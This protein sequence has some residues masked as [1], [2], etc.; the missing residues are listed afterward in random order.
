MIGPRYRDAKTKQ[1]KRRFQLEVLEGRQMLSGATAAHELLQ[2]MT[3]HGVA[4][5]A[6][7]STQ[8]SVA[9]PTLAV[10]SPSQPL[11]G[12]IHLA[13]ANPVI[14][15]KFV[16]AGDWVTL[17]S[18]FHT[19]ATLTFQSP[20]GAQIKIRYGGG[21]IFGWDSQQQTLDGLHAKQLNVSQA[22]S[23]VGARVQIKVQRDTW[24]S[25]SEARTGP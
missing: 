21:W 4:R 6:Q 17:E 15:T 1:R 24:V 20:A 7:V 12:T 23:T 11:A 25:Y 2:G 16:H 9:Q 18:Y 14:K 22:A 8:Q 19:S 3:S 10:L 13:L 5:S